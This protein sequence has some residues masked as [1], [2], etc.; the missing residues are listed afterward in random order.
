MNQTCNKRRLNKSSVYLDEIKSRQM[1]EVAAGHED[2][3]YY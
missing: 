1:D 3:R 2:Y